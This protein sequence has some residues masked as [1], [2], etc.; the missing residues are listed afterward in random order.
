MGLGGRGGATA[1]PGAPLGGNSGGF[2]L[3]SSSSWDCSGYWR[4]DVGLSAWLQKLRGL[5]TPAGA[6]PKELVCWEAGA[7]PG[8]A[9]RRNSWACRG[10]HAGGRG[11]ASSSRPLQT[12]LQPPSVLSG[13]SSGLRAVSAGPSHPQV[14]LELGLEEQQ[15]GLPGPISV[16]SAASPGAKLPRVSLSR[17]SSSCLPVASFSPAQL[18]PPGCLPR[19]HF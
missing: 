15:V 12:H 13:P 9:A 17:T 16:L 14:G 3:F 18:M 7:G 8:D 19:P 4:R 1:G 10:R 5:Q 11:R 6:E 2:R